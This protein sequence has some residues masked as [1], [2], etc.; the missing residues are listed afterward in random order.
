MMRQGITSKLD[1]L[2]IQLDEL[3][4]AIDRKRDEC[5]RLRAINAE[6]LATLRALADL[7]RSTPRPSG[8]HALCRTLLDIEGIARAAIAK[9]EECTR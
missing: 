4:R 8:Q 9:A 2:D 6:L 1:T 7:A 3:D 5:E